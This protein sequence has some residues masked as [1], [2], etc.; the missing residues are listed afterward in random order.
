MRHLNGSYSYYFCVVVKNKRCAVNGVHTFNYR[1]V[2]LLVSRYPSVRIKRPSD[3]PAN[4]R[5]MTADTG[6]LPFFTLFD[7][8]NADCCSFPTSRTYQLTQ[9]SPPSLFS[10]TYLRL[11]LVPIRFAALFSTSPPTPLLRAEFRLD[12]EPRGY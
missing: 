2:R 6:F 1:Y 12:R 10:S 4:R 11:S 3:Q 8:Q 7:V 9:A 5:P